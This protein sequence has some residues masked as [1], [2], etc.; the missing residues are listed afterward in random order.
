MVRFDLEANTLVISSVLLLFFFHTYS[1]GLV[2]VSTLSGLE[3]V[4]VWVGVV[5]T[6]V[7]NWVLEKQG[8]C[9][10]QSA[11][12]QTNLPLGSVFSPVFK[13]SCY[14]M[15]HRCKFHKFGMC[16][17]HLAGADPEWPFVT[18]QSAGRSDASECTL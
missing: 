8:S 5:L 17:K 12:K 13:A 1:L 16:Q 4:L 6:T 10:K 18:T 15:I 14:K 9:D 2:L 7:L 3:K 11:N